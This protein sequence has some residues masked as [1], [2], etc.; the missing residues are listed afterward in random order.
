M[1]RPPSLPGFFAHTDMAPLTCQLS[2]FLELSKRIALEQKLKRIYGRWVRACENAYMHT[3]TCWN[4]F[5]RRY[6]KS[7]EDRHHGIRDCGLLVSKGSQMISI[8]F[9]FAL[10]IFSQVEHILSDFVRR[11]KAWC[12]KEK[13][14]YLCLYLDVRSDT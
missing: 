7:T 12:F 10:C 3:Y 4:V 6:T 5:T 2:R 13:I 8:F 1:L 14:Y 9:F 11:G